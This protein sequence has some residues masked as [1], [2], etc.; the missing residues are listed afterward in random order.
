[1]H[2]VLL[3]VVHVKPPGLEVT[4]YPDILELLFVAGGLHD[5]IAWPT[6]AVALTP[7]GALGTGTCGVTLFDGVDGALVPSDVVA[8]TVNVWGVSF[9]KPLTTQLVAAE[10]VQVN[11]PGCDETV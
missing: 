3:V 11:P 10:V 5:T 6:P 8:V 2:L 4:A 9:T 7:I 1:M